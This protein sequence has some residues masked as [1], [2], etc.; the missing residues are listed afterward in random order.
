MTS[1]SR[2][3]AAPGL[4][5]RTLLRRHLRD[6]APLLLT[7]VMVAVLAGLLTAGSRA[8]TR[9]ADQA[10]GVAIR[11]AE[12][13][14]RDISLSLRSEGMPFVEVGEKDD[15]EA[16]APF[17]VVDQAARGLMG[18]RVAALVGP[19]Q[20]SAQSDY[21]AIS[22]LTGERFADAPIAALRVQPGIDEQVTWVSGGPPG[23]STATVPL[24]DRGGSRTVSVIPVA[25]SQDFAARFQ[26]AVGDRLRL[27]P[28][29]ASDVQGVSLRAVPVQVT[30]IYRAIDQAADF[31]SPEPGMH[32]VGAFP[33]RDGG[34]TPIG[35]V[36]V[37][38][39]G[40][41]ALSGALSPWATGGP[42]AVVSTSAFGLTH[43]WRY[44]VNPDAV[45]ASDPDELKAA[46][47]RL[48]NRTG[49]WPSS[50][51]VITLASGLSTV[52][53]QYR[54]GVQTT[55]AVNSFAIT[56]LLVLGLLG[57]ALTSAVL[58]RRRAPA[59]HLLGVRGVSSSQVGALLAAEAGIASLPAAVLG[60]AAGRL[61]VGGSTQ[62]R[63]PWE[64]IV[65]ALAPV[66]IAAAMAV[67]AARR[68]RE[69]TA[70]PALW[71]TGAEILVVAVTAFA[72]ATAL[73]RGEVGA[74]GDL[75]LAALPALLALSVTLI[76]LRLAAPALSMAGKFAAQ[77]AGFRAMLGLRRAAVGLSG[78][79]L[80]LSTVAVAVALATFLGSAASELAELAGRT[81]YRSVGADVRIDAQRIDDPELAA[82][83][84]RPGVTAAIAAYAA[85]RQVALV[86][87]GVDPARVTVHLIATTA[88]AYRRMLQG[89]PLEF[90]SLPPAAAQ[91]AVVP[92]VVSGGLA[93]GESGVLRIDGIEVRFEVLAVDP[94]LDQSTG[95]NAAPTMLAS[96]PAI[97]SI[98]TVVQANAALLQASSSA[99]ESLIS[100]E[101]TA[102][103]TAVLSR[104]AIET[105]WSANPL[106]SLILSSAAVGSVAAAGLTLMGIL[107]LLSLSRPARLELLV[108]LRTM[109]V[110]PRRDR[111]IGAIETLP[112]VLLAIAVGVATAIVVP[113]VL[114]SALNLGPLV[115]AL[116]VTVTIPPAF[117]GI[118]VLA[119]VDLALL[120][121]IIDAR[122][123]ARSDLAQALRRGDRA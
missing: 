123:A 56:G 30:G 107:L 89:T 109:G 97:R 83:R 31:W 33:G 23:A 73:S 13:G 3:A 40:Y 4:G 46:L 101:P 84:S 120:A 59:V 35:I 12:P 19:V 108:R 32:T 34:A 72:I 115:G 95:S 50:V 8:E 26:V 27:D 79:A 92:V 21:F 119:A 49:P 82:L 14:L 10:L 71:R 17:T 99:A 91:N 100:K 106:T 15:G 102:L 42:G 74:N 81:A 18:P 88:E 47:A 122:Q 98:S 38:E 28:D 55:Q 64:V 11:A 93:V 103:T 111:A 37:G 117:V 90:S 105:T 65:V 104:R 78:S 94:A 86:G 61:L 121:M 5:L 87:D 62:A 16:S 29:G 69:R 51:G 54:S 85:P 7:G 2:H 39:Q 114:S 48:G 52:I 1:S 44:V 113:R 96:L 75:T 58:V 20:V 57:L 118:V 22:R 68:S 6:R 36:V 76:A 24:R 80:G 25:L 70:W 53:D 9:A 41:S 63:I 112:G 66:L 43:V 45:R 60:W 110:E 77:G 116:P 67:V